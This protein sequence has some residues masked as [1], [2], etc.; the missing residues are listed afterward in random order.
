MTW[1]DKF[2]DG[3][4]LTITNALSHDTCTVMTLTGLKLEEYQCSLGIDHIVVEET[5]LCVAETIT[6]FTQKPFIKG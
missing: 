2:K 6:P 1:K 4:T 3:V 5:L